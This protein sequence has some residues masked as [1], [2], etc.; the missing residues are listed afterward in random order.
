[1]CMLNWKKSLNGH[2]GLLSARVGLLGVC[3]GTCCPMAALVPGSPREWAW[4]ATT[5]KYPSQSARVQGP[6]SALSRKFTN[7]NHL[8]L[9]HYLLKYIYFLRCYFWKARLQRAA[10][11]GDGRAVRWVSCRFCCSLPLILFH[12]YYLSS[13]LEIKSTGGRTFVSCSSVLSQ[14]PVQRVCSGPSEAP[15]RWGNGESRCSSGQGVCLRGE[16]QHRTRGFTARVQQYCLS[17][18]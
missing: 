7:S 5:G 2:K 1:M 14:I 18:V 13:D 11:W 8:V 17:R 4:P 10:V 6:Y 16:L 12:F 3:C 9:N 15:A